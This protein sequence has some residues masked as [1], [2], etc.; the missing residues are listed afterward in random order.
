MEELHIHWSEFKD[1]GWAVGACRL[2][3]GE[4]PLVSAQLGS[5]STCV[6]THQAV[7]E[8]TAAVGKKKYKVCRGG[9]KGRKAA[10]S[11]WRPDRLKRLPG[12]ARCGW[13]WQKSV[14]FAANIAEDFCQQVRQREKKE[15]GHAVRTPLR[16]RKCSK[17]S[18]GQINTD[19]TPFRMRHPAHS[20]KYCTATFW[21]I[22]R[23]C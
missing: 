17:F 19:R 15:R 1:D 7:I 8:T 10:M 13:K 6:L 4:H 18:P 2:R 21:T 23:S 20:N 9:G 5:R 3:P 14:K 22:Q 11:A 12:S 16:G